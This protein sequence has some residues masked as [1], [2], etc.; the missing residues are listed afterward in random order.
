M[1]PTSTS[2]L[3]KQAVKWCYSPSMASGELQG[4]MCAALAP[5][6]TGH[7]GRLSF[8]TCFLQLNFHFSISEIQT[9]ETP[10]FFVL[11]HSLICFSC[12]F[13]FLAVTQSSQK[14]KWYKYITVE[15]V[16]GSQNQI[17]SNQ[18]PTSCRGLILLHQ[19]L[20]ASSFTLFSA[21]TCQFKDPLWLFKHALGVLLSHHASCW[22]ATKTVVAKRTPEKALSPLFAYIHVT[23]FWFSSHLNIFLSKVWIN[24]IRL[25]K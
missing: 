21:Y 2:L 10:N 19:C 7:L 14:H 4:R 23:Y 18:A 3:R 6:S 15:V 24:S 5:Y 12:S 1:L 8:P 9:N 11:H 16:R 17:E 25:P 20:C 13:P 22:Y